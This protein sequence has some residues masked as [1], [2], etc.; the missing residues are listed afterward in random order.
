MSKSTLGGF[1]S[2]GEMCSTKALNAGTF[3]EIFHRER[4]DLWILLVTIARTHQCFATKREV[5]I[6]TWTSISPGEED[7]SEV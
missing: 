5:V 6:E 2:P 1:A 3:H 4:L 7:V